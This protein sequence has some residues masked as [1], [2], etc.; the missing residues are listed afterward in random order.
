[1]LVNGVSMR[2][3]VEVR[4]FWFN[5]KGEIWVLKFIW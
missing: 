2:L 3:M 5:L 1:M 4:G